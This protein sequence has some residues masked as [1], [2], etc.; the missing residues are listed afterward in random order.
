MA[1][2]KQAEAPKEQPKKVS[3]PK[4]L[5]RWARNYYIRNFGHVKVGDAVTKEA[6]TA[7]NKISK[8]KPQT[9]A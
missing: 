8:A 1:K 6:L 5:G 2:Q 3:K 4:A 7:W 9:E